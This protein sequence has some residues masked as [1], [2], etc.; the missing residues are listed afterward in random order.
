ML[1]IQSL[2]L[3]NTKISSVTKSILSFYKNILLASISTYSIVANF[4]QN[5]YNN[6]FVGGATLVHF[7][8]KDK[9][10]S[11]NEVLLWGR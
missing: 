6:V 9:P 2:L 1:S 11:H 8:S 4:Y 10:A 7:I 5:V 3:F